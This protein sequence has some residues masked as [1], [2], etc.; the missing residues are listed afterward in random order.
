MEN[1]V[2]W[3]P[4]YITDLVI[5]REGKRVYFLLCF[6]LSPEWLS[7]PTVHLTLCTSITSI[8]DDLAH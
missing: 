4:S 2:N 5:D 7:L 1:Q 8:W 6:T 3:D